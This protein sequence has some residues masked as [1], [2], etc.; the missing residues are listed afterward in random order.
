MINIKIFARGETATSAIPLTVE[1]TV[2]T[3]VENVARLQRVTDQLDARLQASEAA[4]QVSHAPAS[5]TRYLTPAFTDNVLDANDNVVGVETTFSCNEQQTAVIIRDTSGNTPRYLK[6]DHSNLS[7]GYT[8]NVANVGTQA[9]IL[10][11]TANFDIVKGDGSSGATLT[12][13]GQGS[14][15][16]ATLLFCGDVWA[17]V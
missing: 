15:Y 11:D 6:L 13:G 14:Q 9:A 17:V 8:L 10:S 3:V 4:Q 7:A 16:T 12:L 1:E 2:I 5:T